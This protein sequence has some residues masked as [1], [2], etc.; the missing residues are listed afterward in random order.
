VLKVDSIS[1][2]R[3]HT[4]AGDVP[5][6]RALST[7]HVGFSSQTALREQPGMTTKS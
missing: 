6:A 2:N 4:L 3:T 7:P 1:Y 5:H